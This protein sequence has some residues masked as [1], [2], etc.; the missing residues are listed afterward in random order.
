[1]AV[2]QALPTAATFGEMAEPL[3]VLR[4]GASHHGPTRH[5][6]A[7]I[8]MRVWAALAT[9]GC[10]ALHIKVK[11]QARQA[12]AAAA[13]AA[14]A[15]PPQTRDASTSFEFSPINTGNFAASPRLE[16]GPS[17][18]EPW[19]SLGQVKTPSPRQGA[20]RWSSDASPSSPL[21]LRAR[22]SLRAPASRSPSAG[23]RRSFG[24]SRAG[25]PPQQVLAAG[26]AA[27]GRDGV[28]WA[29]VGPAAE[30]AGWW[31]PGKAGRASSRS[32]ER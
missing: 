10:L 11:Q 9:I 31:S 18:P 19:D 21:V 1:M 3:K 25:S 5:V 4:A 28:V 29:A 8:F 13:A 15:A 6:L 26:D 23:R 30:F 27:L 20:A 17:S 12:Q 7:D 2:R 24:S 32:G 16:D 14:A 22:A